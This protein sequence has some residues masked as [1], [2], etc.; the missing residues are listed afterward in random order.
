[1]SRPTLEVADIVRASGNRFWEH[2]GSRLAWQHRKVLD[3]IVRC[4]TAALALTVIS[5]R[6]A[7]IRLSLTTHAVT[8][9]APDVR[10][11]PAPA[12]SPSAGLS[13]CPSLTFTSSS[14]CRTHSPL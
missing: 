10:G 13:C 8:G 1:M 9:T 14:R 12:G 7:D 2:Y 6:A 11:T 4:R 5:A 3:A